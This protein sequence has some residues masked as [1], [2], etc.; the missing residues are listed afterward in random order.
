MIEK[1]SS[2]DIQRPLQEREQHSGKA[3]L[4]LFGVAKVSFDIFD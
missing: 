4:K 2:G 3:H 1:K